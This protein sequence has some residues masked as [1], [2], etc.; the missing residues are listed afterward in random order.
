MPDAKRRRVSRVGPRTERAVLL[1]PIL[2]TIFVLV[3]CGGSQGTP[4]SDSTADRNQLRVIST[5]VLTDRMRDLTI[6]SPA[7]GHP[8]TVRLLL[9]A[10]FKR[11][12]DKLPVL[13]LLHG[14]CDTY[15]SW[16]RST[17]IADLS[18]HTEVLIV[19]PDAGPVGFYSNWLKGP[20]WEDF[21][22]VELP[23]ILARDY[24]AS[25][26][27]AVAGNSMGGLGALSYA[28]RHPG[29][30]QAA[31]SFSGI[32]HTKL[33]V[34]ESAGWENLVSSQGEDP[35]DLWG[36]AGANVATWK[37]HNPY[38]LAPRLRGTQLYLSCGGGRLGPLDTDQQLA[39]IETSL[40][41]E[42]DAFVHHLHQL[43][44]SATIHMYDPGIHNWPYWQRELHRAW[45]MLTRAISTTTR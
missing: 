18:A 3:G 15:R 42:N 5:S 27:R 7:V 24:R 13:Y 25:T 36:E 6:D 41:A 21:H 14:C 11:S 9:P 33:T 44:I 19:M 10:D 2:V 17:D 22:L 30:F 34:T 32:V 38:D 1:A 39:G 16:T 45:P 23:R 40:R 26:T 35:L 31:A 8:V 29:M 28:A 4:R 20:Q 12:K 37:A 43:R